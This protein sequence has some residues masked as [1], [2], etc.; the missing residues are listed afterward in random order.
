MYDA[1]RCGN[2][3]REMGNDA[4]VLPPVGNRKIPK[5]G[6]I[7]QLVLHFTRNR[8]KV[9]SASIFVRRRAAT[10]SAMRIHFHRLRFSIFIPTYTQIHHPRKNIPKKKIVK[11]IKKQLTNSENAENEIKKKK[12]SSCNTH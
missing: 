4:E 11:C 1:Y 6:P 9:A 7:Y 8:K 12:N 3:M 5:P 2:D 10:V